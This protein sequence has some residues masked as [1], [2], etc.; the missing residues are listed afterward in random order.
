MVLKNF[1][2]LAVVVF[3]FLL[4]SMKLLTNSKSLKTIGAWTEGHQKMFFS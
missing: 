3:N 2:Q 1:E 4:A